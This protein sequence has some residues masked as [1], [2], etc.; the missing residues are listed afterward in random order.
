MDIDSARKKVETLRAELERANVA[1]Y[2]EKEPVMS[3]AEWDALFDELA[4]IEA[5][6]PALVTPDSPT[7]RV[8]AKT[9]VASEFAPVKHATPMLSL[10]KANAEEEVREWDA[11][12]RK[13]LGLAESASVR[14]ACEPK[15]DGLSIELVYRDGALEVASTR[16][17]GFVGEDVT[18]NIRAIARVP[19]RLADGAP[20]LLEVRGEIY[21][22]IEGFQQLNKRL[23][24]EGKPMV[25]NPRNAAAG[26]LRQKDPEVTRARP[27]EFLAHG[28]GR[29]EGLEARSHSEGLAGLRRLGLPTTEC[30]TIATIPELFE[31]YRSILAEREKLPYEMDGIVVKVDDFR[32]QEECGWVSRSPRWALAYKFPPVQR[33]TKILRIIPS[34]G[35]TGAVTPFA[36]LEPV[37]LS[38]ARVKQ[39]SLFNIDEIR[40]KDIR[41]GDVALV[42]RGGEV[43]PNVVKVYPEERPPGGLPEWRLPETCPACGA[44]IERPEGEAVAY[45]T[46]ARCPIQVVQ[47]IFHFAS[48]GAMDIQGLGERTIEAL[49]EAGLIGD[50]GD[51]FALPEKR[52]ALLGIERMGE[53][54]VENLLARI[55]AAKDR[56][57]ARLVHGLGIRHVGETVAQTL[58]RAIPKLDVLAAASEERLLEI[59]GVGPVVAKSV[60]NFFHNPDTE[61]LLKKLR[62]AAARGQ[63]RI[64]DEARP[65]GP[66]PFAGKTFVVTGSFESWTREALKAALEGYGAKVASSV[67]KKTDW[68]V[69]GT[70]AGAKLDRAKE[71]GRPVLSEAELKALVAEAL[72]A[73][74]AG[75]KTDPAADGEAAIPTTGAPSAPPEEGKP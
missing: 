9:A 69:A 19:K 25:A 66:K 4:K 71:L 24:A 13:L 42:Q 61:V 47:R 12:V 55:G 72:A 74:A 33:R 62:D 17:D 34:V 49:R 3:D 70:D 43:I 15:Y 64:E 50:V 27:L 46:G 39:A 2:V 10:G 18:A 58:A 37:I 5:E 45:C 36:E 41:E 44:K 29:F 75:P 56:P 52:E 7:Q 22:P 23:E 59:K 14:Y 6:F 31:F 65:E 54:T 16:G 38:G 11:R 63:L 20:H 28:L 1:Y 32:L 8:G 40:R 68:V 26:S 30:V 67:S 60:F 57:L 48:R 51:V 73:E 53:K 21:M 35:R